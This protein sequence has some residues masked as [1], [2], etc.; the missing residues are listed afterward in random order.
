MILPGFT[1]ETSLYKTSGQYYTT[2]ALRPIHG[3]VSPAAVDRG[4]ASCRLVSDWPDYCYYCEGFDSSTGLQVSWYEGDGCNTIPTTPCEPSSD[5]YT[6]GD[7]CNVCTSI[8]GDCSMLVTRDCSNVIL[9]A[10]RTRTS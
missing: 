5:C 2:H 7:Q 1:A 10:F 4:S 8:A 9:P 3:A 6:D